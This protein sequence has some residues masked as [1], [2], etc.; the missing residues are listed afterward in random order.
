ML[1]FSS[2]L[3]LGSFNSRSPNFLT[4]G[5]KASRVGQVMAGEQG[6]RERFCSLHSDLVP[7]QVL[8][9]LGRASQQALSSVVSFAEASA[10]S[11]HWI[12]TPASVPRSLV[13]PPGF[14][15]RFIHSPSSHLQLDLGSLHSTS[16]GPQEI[17]MLFRQM[18][19]ASA[20]SNAANFSLLHSGSSYSLIF[21]L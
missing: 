19:G 3:S 2:I 1:S 9:G 5:F 21:S 15:L 17:S 11:P 6:K 18:L 20:T 16:L 4:G 12:F 10:L 8:S 7:T 13:I 14:P